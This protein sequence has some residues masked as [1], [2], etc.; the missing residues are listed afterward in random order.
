[1]KGIRAILKPLLEDTP[2]G[3]FVP[4]GRVE[5]EMFGARAKSLNTEGPQSARLIFLVGFRERGRDAPADLRPFAS[6]AGRIEVP[7]P[8]RPIFEFSDNAEPTFEDP[9]PSVGKLAREVALSFDESFNRAPASDS[10]AARLRLPEP[11]AGARFAEIGVELEINGVVESPQPDNDRLDLILKE[12]A[13]V[14]LLDEDEMPM[15]G[16]A[17]KVMLGDFEVASGVLDDNGF[18]RIEGLPV[19]QCS[20]S[21]P[22]LGEATVRVMPRE[23]VPPELL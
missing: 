23:E 9:P 1:M 11:P 2:V 10:Q 15:S 20:V 4:A 17:Y 8:R 12:F 6:Y 21:F 19:G 5:L 7:D 3:V 14:T 18:A 16:T 22:D 13:E